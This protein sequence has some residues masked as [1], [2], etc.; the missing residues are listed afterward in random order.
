VRYWILRRTICRLFGHRAEF[1]KAATHMAF[2]GV[3]YVA[4]CTRC[5]GPRHEMV[6][7]WNSLVTVS[8]VNDYV[9]R[10]MVK[11]CAAVERDR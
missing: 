5:W 11:L 7:K 2:D 3:K 4:T 10:E 8:Q 9:E 6:I 1:Q